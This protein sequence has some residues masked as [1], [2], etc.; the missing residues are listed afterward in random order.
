MTWSLNP[1]SGA[2]LTARDDAV[3]TLVPAAESL[4]RRVTGVE[5]KCG[6]RPNAEIRLTSPVTFTD[7]IGR[8]EVVVA[9]FP[10]RGSIRFDLWIEH[11][12]VFARLDGSPTG[13][14][15]YLNDYVASLSLE[16]GAVE[17]S[18]DFV[19]DVVAGVHAARDA[20]RRYNARSKADWFKVRIT[21]SRG[22]A[23]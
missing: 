5:P 15:C 12:R 2:A 1:S 3:G 7:G 4:L 20:V 11:D 8:G 21:T 16:P 23:V 19:R 10:Y 17:L 22:G 9:I 14:S 6:E 18:A 13:S